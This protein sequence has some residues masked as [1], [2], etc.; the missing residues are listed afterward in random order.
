MLISIENNSSNVHPKATGYHFTGPLVLRHNLSTVLPTMK[1]IHKTLYSH[2]RILSMFFIQYVYI[3]LNISHLFVQSLQSHK[4]GHE[5]YTHVLFHTAYILCLSPTPLLTF[6]TL[7]HICHR[8][9]FLISLHFQVLFKLIRT[10]L[11]SILCY[12]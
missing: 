9:G 4:K 6:P 11:Q 2:M 5:Q 3:A 8:N 7:H 1:F 10:V 12:H